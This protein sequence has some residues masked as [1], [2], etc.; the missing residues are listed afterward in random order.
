M[1]SLFGNGLK[2]N[3]CFWHVPFS[4]FCKRKLFTGKKSP[5][6][7]ENISF[8]GPYLNLRTPEYKAELLTTRPWLPLLQ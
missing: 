6:L 2:D 8:P 5:R 1:A 4:H 7:F 3:F